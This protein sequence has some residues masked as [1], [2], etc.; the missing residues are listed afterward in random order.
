MTRSV[1][2][3]SIL[4]LFLCANARWVHAE[5]ITYEEAIGALEGAQ[6]LR[7]DQLK[8]WR[9][10]S[11]ILLKQLSKNP[12]GPGWA[13]FGWSSNLDAGDIDTLWKLLYLA[14]Q[15]GLPGREDMA[16]RLILFNIAHRYERVAQQRSALMQDAPIYL[17]GLAGMPEYTRYMELSGERDRLEV[18]AMLL[19]VSYLKQ[20]SGADALAP[21]AWKNSMTETAPQFIHFRKSVEGLHVEA[22]ALARRYGADITRNWPGYLANLLEDVRARADQWSMAQAADISENTPK[23]GLRWITDLFREDETADKML[24]TYFL[25]DDANP[26]YTTQERQLARKVIRALDAYREES[27]RFD[28]TPLVNKAEK[29]HDAK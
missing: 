20:E 19:A 10:E 4:C 6:R 3:L 7:Q 29:L 16:P 9:G 28:L 17:R 12:P 18:K 15:L 1:F 26:A 22:Q 24:R 13:S 8:L 23:D 5:R 25:E 27:Y 14:K 21:D 2:V 11:D